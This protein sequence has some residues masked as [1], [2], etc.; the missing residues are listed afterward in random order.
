MNL[1]PVYRFWSFLRTKTFGFKQ[2]KVTPREQLNQTPTECSSSS[3]KSQSNAGSRPEYSNAKYLLGISDGQVTTHFSINPVRS[4][5][6]VSASVMSSI[7][8][9]EFDEAVNPAGSILRNARLAA[10]GQGSLHAGVSIG[11]VL[12]MCIGFDESGWIK[13]PTGLTLTFSSLSEEEISTTN[14]FSQ[15]TSVQKR[16]TTKARSSRDKRADSRRQKKAPTDKATKSPAA[17]LPGTP[18]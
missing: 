8:R 15:E 5:S 4:L 18:S 2:T 10:D 1:M 13:P 3:D 11:S 7:K 16:E 17:I 12:V 9:G 14:R 6:I